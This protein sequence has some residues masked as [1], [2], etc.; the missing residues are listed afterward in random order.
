M[1]YILAS[2]TYSKYGPYL[3]RLSMGGQHLECI[4]YY[5]FYASTTNKTKRK[6]HDA[7]L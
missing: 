7:L 1:A 2:I 4:C 5:Y 3:K 6:I